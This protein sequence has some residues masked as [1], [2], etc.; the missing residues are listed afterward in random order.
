MISKIVVLLIKPI[1]FVAFPLPSP[2]SNLKVPNDFPE[3]GGGGGTSLGIVGWGCAAGTLE[4]L[5][6]TRASSNEFCYPLFLLD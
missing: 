4:S 1:A 6:C 5:A 3:R 2:S